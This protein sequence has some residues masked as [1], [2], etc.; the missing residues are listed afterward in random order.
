MSDRLPAAILGS[1]DL[2][3]TRLGYGGLELKGPAVD[4][5]DLTHGEAAEVLD[6]VLDSGITLIDTADC[7]GISEETIGRHLSDRRSEYVLATKAGCHRDAPPSGGTK[8]L[9][10]E[11]LVYN[12][13]RSLRRL[14]TDHID[15]L[16][17]HTPVVKR[18]N[19][20]VLGHT[21]R[22]EIIATLEDMRAQGKFRWLGVSTN[23]PH[24]A[25][26]F[27]WG[28]FDAY[29]LPYSVFQRE[30]EEWITKLAGL[31][32]GTI[33]RSGAAR[34]EPDHEG[35]VAY[36][37]GVLL[38]PETRWRYF[39]S[40]DL[41]SLRDPGGQPDR[42]HPALLPGPSRHPYRRQRHGRP[43]GA[44]R[45]RAHRGARPAAARRRRRSQPPREHGRHDVPAKIPSG[46]QI[47]PARPLRPLPGPL[48]PL[49]E[50]RTWTRITIGESQADTFR[51]D[52][53]HRPPL[54]LKV[55]PVRRR[56][57]L[58]R[59]KERIEWLRG[60]LPVPEVLAY[61][62]DC[63]EEYLLLS[64]LP[65]RDAATLTGDRPDDNMVRLLANGLRSIHAVPIDECPFEMSLDRMIEEAGRNVARG[66]VDEADFDDERR[67]RSAAEMFEELL[68]RRLAEEDL[69]FT[70][71]DYCLPN[72]S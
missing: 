40:L 51:L 28:V 62:T 24:L 67:G 43:R 56:R 48:R 52:R 57:D 36:L 12:V 15:L 68:S 4:G 27:N 53:S 13:E 72:V 26:F 5:R 29:M 7:Y 37:Q 17:I 22:E 63:R 19:R 3:V 50:G 16:Q 2:E 11:G 60:R 20:P 33:I 55:S 61:E 44:Q 39:Q 8:D 64:A 32:L 42:L 41:D 70:H 30:H 34:G 71:G 25:H 23:L 47:H 45:E 10:R 38:S 49:A 14:R 9:T 31:G 6:A 54:Y 58:L 65:G 69:V 21:E 35:S 59:E 66:L 46:L 1:T 18:G